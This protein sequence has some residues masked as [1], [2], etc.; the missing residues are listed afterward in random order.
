MIKAGIIDPVKVIRTAL[1]DAARY[2]SKK[3]APRF[4]R[5]TIRTIKACLRI[6]DAVGQC[7]PADGN[8]G[9]RCL[10]APGNQ[11]QNSQPYAADERDGLL[12][13]FRRRV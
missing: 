3:T 13:K 5:T 6:C 8:H 7:F 11:V 12:R 4:F 9:G 2:I 10:R 1:Q